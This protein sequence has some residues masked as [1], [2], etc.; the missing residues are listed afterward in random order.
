MKPTRHLLMLAAVF[1]LTS[2]AWAE[3]PTTPTR[4]QN[5][6]HTPAQKTGILAKMFNP[7]CRPSQPAPAAPAPIIVQPPAAPVGPDPTTIQMIGQVLGNQGMILYQIG[8]LQGGQT[9]PAPPVTPIIVNP[10]APV[11]VPA[12]TPAPQ[13]PIGILAPLVYPQGVPYAPQP[14]PQ[15]YAPQPLPQGYNPQP[16]PQQYAPQPLPQGYAP[17]PLPHGYAPQQ[18]IVMPQGGG[19]ATPT[20][21]A[22]PLPQSYNPSPPGAIPPGYSPAPRSAPP[23][24]GGSAPGLD[25][26]IYGPTAPP[27]YVPPTGDTRNNGSKAPPAA[28]PQVYT[29]EPRPARGSR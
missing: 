28:Q 14:L 24:G 10:P 13:A 11:P 23:S 29:R 9:P 5:I 25:L 22:Q 19:G 1:V 26:H 15:G 21:P 12:P 20:P 17:Q 27:G 6:Q 16:L 3:Q 4:S 7:A 8:K 18:I 2:L